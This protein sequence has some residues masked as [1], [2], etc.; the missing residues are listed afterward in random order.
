M[1]TNLARRLSAAEV[2]ELA[3]ATENRRPMVIVYLA[4]TGG[5]SRRLVSDLEVL[6]PH[7]QAYCHERQDE[8]T[9]RLD[10]ILSVEPVG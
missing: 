8:R 4:G 9:F 5:T 6:P 1:L 2:H 7:L 10:R 3:D